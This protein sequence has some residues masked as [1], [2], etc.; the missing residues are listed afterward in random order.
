M[1]LKG[2]GVG[3]VDGVGLV[4]VFGNVGQMQAEGFAETTEFDLAVVFDAELECLVNNLL[5]VEVGQ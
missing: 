3:E 1:R 2:F 5:R 4:S